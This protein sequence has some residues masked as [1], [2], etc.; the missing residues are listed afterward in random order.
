MSAGKELIR[1]DTVKVNSPLDGYVPGMFITQPVSRTE[2]FA[3]LSRE[4]VCGFARTER[5]LRIG[6]KT[7]FDVAVA[8]LYIEES[9]ETPVAG[10]TIPFH[11]RRLQERFDASVYQPHIEDYLASY[12][13]SDRSAQ[14]ATADTI[15]EYLIGTS[16][17]ETPTMDFTQDIDKPTQEKPRLYEVLDVDDE[18]E[19]PQPP[20]GMKYYVCLGGYKNFQC[21]LT[22]DNL[23]KGE[24]LDLFEDELDE[25]LLPV[26][27]DSTLVVRQDAK[28]AIPGFYI[29]S[30]KEHYRGID[31]MP[32]DV[33]EHSLLM[34]HRIKQH[35]SSIGIV[36]SH[37]YHDEKYNSP[38]SAHFWVLPLHKTE[39]SH[40]L[41]RT[42]HSRDIWTYL[43]TYDRFSTTREDIVQYNAF[44]RQSLDDLAA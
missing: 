40:A 44:M 41:N 4:E 8:G 33:F 34:A 12:N 13:E 17:K 30:P 21:Y 25:A 29:V 11:I 16:H 32:E 14:D 5:H 27:E 20:K 37:I 23:S 7:M 35:L 31:E 24:F 42:I 6:L 10:Y 38:A 2:K 39:D 15:R 9:P 43:E 28:Y 19:L 3:D 22:K 26:Y 36:D 1:T 18:L